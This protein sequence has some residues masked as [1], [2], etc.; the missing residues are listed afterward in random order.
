MTT[1]EKETT[2][3]IEI[4]GHHLDYLVNVFE[5]AF[6]AER[7]DL[8][9]HIPEIR[10]QMQASQ[11]SHEADVD[12][13]GYLRLSHKTAEQLAELLDKIT[14]QPSGS[15]EVDQATSEIT[16]QLQSEQPYDQNI[17]VLYGT[18]YAWTEVAPG[19]P[20]PVCPHH[21]TERQRPHPP[22]PLSAVPHRH[23]H[24]RGPDLSGQPQNR[25]DENHP[26]NPQG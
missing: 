2:V 16:Q 20:R 25:T 4:S 17:R 9:A 1:T 22:K 18:R 8:L 21:H 13:P 14:D 10:R 26:R 5:N 11:I 12:P 7:D 23:R 15:Y 24:R 3:V 6:P 19:G